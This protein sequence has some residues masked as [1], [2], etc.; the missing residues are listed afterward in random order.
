MIYVCFINPINTVIE[1]EFSL[2]EQVPTPT[3]GEELFGLLEKFVT[4]SGLFWFICINVS[5]N[6]ATAIGGQHLCL[7]QVKN[8]APN[9]VSYYCFIHCEALVAKETGEVKTANFIKA[10]SLNSHV[11]EILNSEMGSEYVLIPLH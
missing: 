10:S 9:D 4:E 8:A 2:R 7:V 1:E 6:E 5:M 11:L 3:T